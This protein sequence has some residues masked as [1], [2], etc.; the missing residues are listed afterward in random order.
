MEDQALQS[1]RKTAGKKNGGPAPISLA[2]KFSE[3]KIVNAESALEL[4]VN[5][6]RGEGVRSQ[7]SIKGHVRA[8]IA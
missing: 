2:G 4:L 8:E 3:S 6:E 1:A 7:L 5:A